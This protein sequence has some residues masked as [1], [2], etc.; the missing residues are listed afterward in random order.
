MGFLRFRKSI[1]LAPGVKINLN[2]K[3]VSLT[4][5]GK[6][7]HHTIGTRGSQTTI[8]LPGTGLSYT[9]ITPRKST[10]ASASSGNTARRS[11]GNK[12]SVCP[13]CGHRMRKQWDNCPKCHYPL[14]VQTTA[15]AEADDYASV[16]ENQYIADVPAVQDQYYNQPSSPEILPP[17]GNN[18]QP[19]SEPPEDKKS[20]KTGCGCFIF[21]ILFIMGLFN[22]CFGDTEEDKQPVPQPVP[23]Q[24]QQVK[25]QTETKP[26]ETK[27]APPAA[28]A[29]PAAVPAAVPAEPA[30]APKKN[31]TYVANGNTGKIHREGCR[32]VRRMKE[33]NKIYIEGTDAAK[34]SGYSPCKSCRPF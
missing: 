29:A 34:A 26:A 8:G 20:N 14:T 4:T 7:F 10:S 12:M 9:H 30:Q 25:Q 24:T 19:P 21:L 27:S 15:T 23:A 11:T 13:K 1:K 5:G 28:T 2:K 17:D 18:N 32:Y 33:G 16:S 3:S 6:G 31:I 22:S